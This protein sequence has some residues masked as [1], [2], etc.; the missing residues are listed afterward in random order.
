MF[1]IEKYSILTTFPHFSAHQTSTIQNLA[2]TFPLTYKDYSLIL[3]YLKSEFLFKK[4]L[5]V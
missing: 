3:L 5:N 4:N 1:E 2:A